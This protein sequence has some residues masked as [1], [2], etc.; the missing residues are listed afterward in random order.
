MRILEIVFL[1]L[2]LA[3]LIWSLK[4]NAV[5]SRAFSVLWGCTFLALMLHLIIEGWRWQ[6]VPGYSVGAAILI[7]SA[8]RKFRERDAEDQPRTWFRSALK[9]LL[10]G[11]AILLVLISGILSW[12]FPVFKLPVPTGP[13]QVGKSQW[14]LLDKSREETH[15]VEP[16][17]FRE[18]SVLSWYPAEASDMTKTAAPSYWCMALEHP[19][20]SGTISSARWRRPAFTSSAMTSSDEVYRIGRACTRLTFRIGNY[21]NCSIRRGLTRPWIWPAYRWAAPSIFLAIG[22]TVSGSPKESTKGRR[23]SSYSK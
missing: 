14:F 3:A 7:I 21:L 20:L 6:M 2:T 16:G 5:K 1:I 10:S 9:V 17:D 4:R 12:A 19:C 15:T 11:A 18:I 23:N 13:Y 8:A 22:L